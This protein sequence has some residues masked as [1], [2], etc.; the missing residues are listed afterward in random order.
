MFTSLRQNIFEK[1]T[2]CKCVMLITKTF[3]GSWRKKG[4][5]VWLKYTKNEKH[6]IIMCAGRRENK[7]AKAKAFTDKAGF[8][9]TGSY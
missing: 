3:L 7:R 4:I 1:V 6:T 2:L 8:S 9:V 5:L